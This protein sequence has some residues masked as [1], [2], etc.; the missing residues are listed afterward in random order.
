M[1]H[2]FHFA[3]YLKQ[4][5]QPDGKCSFMYFTDGQDRVS[6]RVRVWPNLLPKSESLEVIQD[7]LLPPSLPHVHLHGAQRTPAKEIS[8]LA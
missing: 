5:L 4:H 8:N 2:V 7:P 6:E 3:W 1:L